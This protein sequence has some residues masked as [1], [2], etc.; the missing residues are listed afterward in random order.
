MSCFLRKV[1]PWWEDSPPVISEAARTKG[2][3]LMP[4]ADIHALK[5]EWRGVWAR[6]GAQALRNPNAAFL[7]WLAKRVAG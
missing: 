5:A 3:A 6:T 1:A 2:R 7:G 4:G